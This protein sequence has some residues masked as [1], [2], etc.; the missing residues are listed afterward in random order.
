MEPGDRNEGKDGQ[1]PPGGCFF[2]FSTGGRIAPR[3]PRTRKLCHLIVTVWRNPRTGLSV[4]H[5]S[6]AS[7]PQ[8]V[9]STL[10]PTRAL[11]AALEGRAFT[12]PERPSWSPI[13]GTPYREVL[14]GSW[15]MG[16]ERS[17]V[18][19]HLEAVCHSVSGRLRW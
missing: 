13:P 17:E 11:I 12:V 5:V 8:G 15:I 3:F 7:L 14:A 6:N 1:R 18:T 10:Y 19:L 2:S 9:G 4:V 16:L